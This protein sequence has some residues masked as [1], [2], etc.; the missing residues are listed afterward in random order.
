MCGRRNDER[1]SKWGKITAGESV[2]K[3]CRRMLYNSCNFYI[4]WKLYKNL[5]NVTRYIYI[6]VV[7]QIEDELVIKMWEIINID[8]QIF[9]E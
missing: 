5:Q 6:Y 3:A 7:I 2:S 8:I 4:V 9:F 1:H